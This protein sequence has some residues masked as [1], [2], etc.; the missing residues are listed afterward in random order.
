[1]K[2]AA[3]LL[4]ACVVLGAVAGCGSSSS[5][6]TASGSSATPPS[7]TSTAGGLKLTTTPRY[8]SPP[9]SAPVQS[10]VVHVSYRD[11]TIRPD[12]LKVRVGSTVVWTNED[13]I[14]HNV[15]SQSGPVRFA[16]KNIR[17]GQTFS[18]KLTRPGVIHY[19]CTIHP[20]SMNGTIE[21]V[22]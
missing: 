18:V 1:M 19:L 15:T 13:P 9:A 3:A 4:A 7:G 14:E 16:S 2:A 8:A 11:V 5:S 10:G 20:A 17:E 12:T 6:R 22:R 21:V